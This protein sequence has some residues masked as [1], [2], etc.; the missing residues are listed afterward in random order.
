[1]SGLGKL[2]QYMPSVYYSSESSSCERTTSAR[3]LEVSVSEGLSKTCRPI[4]SFHSTDKYNK[5]IHPS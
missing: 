3:G 2:F 5:Y 1:M 4:W